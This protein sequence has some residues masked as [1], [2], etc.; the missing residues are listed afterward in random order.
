MQCMH[1]VIGDDDASQ[2]EHPSIS[3]FESRKLYRKENMHVYLCVCTEERMKERTCV[4]AVLKRQC[5]GW[6]ESQT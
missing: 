1:D 4:C 6:R 3:K 5:N 2:D